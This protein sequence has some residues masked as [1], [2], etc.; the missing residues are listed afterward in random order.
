ML[1]EKE[2]C[3]E[4]NPIVGGSDSKIKCTHSC[5]IAVQKLDI[6]CELFSL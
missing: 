6:P 1:T 4:E 2:I 5:R 3:E